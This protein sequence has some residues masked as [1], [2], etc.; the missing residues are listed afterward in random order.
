MVAEVRQFVVTVP[1]GTPVGTPQVSSLGMP[2]RIVRGVR[3]RIPPGPRGEL[4]WALGAAGTAV[5]PWNPGEWII[6]DNELVE[7][8]LDGMI[9]SG[10]WQLIA[11]N[12]G[13][14]DHGLYLTFLLDLVQSMGTTPAGVSAPLSSAAIV[15][16]LPSPLAALPAYGGP[17]STGAASAV[18]TS[19]PSGTVVPAGMMLPSAIVT[20]LSGGVYDPTVLADLAAAEQADPSAD[21]SGIDALVRLADSLYGQLAAAR[22][23]AR[24]WGYLVPATTDQLAYWSAR[25]FGQEILGTTRAGALDQAI[26]RL[27]TYSVTRPPWT[28]AV[29]THQS[30]G[31]L[32]SRPYLSP[33]TL[34]ALSDQEI[35]RLSLT[36]AE[37]IQPLPT[38]QP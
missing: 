27:A 11:Y 13:A 10:A 7:W 1:A 3:V 32:E 23:L 17:P 31:P 14:Y 16:A 26:V 34:A 29:F 35:G 21:W 18:A 24:Q 37:R 22:A 4:G 33:W 36:W 12:T 28:L 30:A 19:L 2:P 9:D 20:R 6:G 15:A 38:G 25:A 5:L 8:A